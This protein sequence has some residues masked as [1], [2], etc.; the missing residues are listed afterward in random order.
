[1]EAWEQLSARGPG[2][3]W[4]VGGLRHGDL[5]HVCSLATAFGEVHGPGRPIYLVVGSQGQ[6]Q[7]GN[8]FR[9]SFQE[10]VVAHG[11][12]AHPDEWR[13]F[14]KKK[15]LPYFGPDLPLLI[16]PQVSLDRERFSLDFATRNGLTWMQLYKQILHLPADVEPEAPQYRPDSAEDA[17]ALAK[18]VDMPA[19]KSVLLFPYAQSL[20]V[21]ANT[22]FA[23]LAEDLAA[24]GHSVFTSVAPNE[25]PIPGTQPIFVPF[26][27][28]PDL[29]EHA[30]WAVAVRSGICDVLAPVRC[31]KSFIYPNMAEL[32]P[33]SVNAMDYCRD[34]Y[35][36]TFDFN[37]RTQQDFSNLIRS[38]LDMGPLVARAHQ[39][40]SFL[41]LGPGRCDITRL[42]LAE[43]DRGAALPSALFGEERKPALLV[44]QDI[45][46]RA[47]PRFESNT[48]RQLDEMV[49]R[50]PGGTRFFTCRDR[51]F[52]DYF[53]EVAAG[54]LV[55]GLYTA[56]RHW[57]TIAM[58]WETDLPD[59]LPDYAREKVLPSET[60]YADRPIRPSDYHGNANHLA[61]NVGHRPFSC[62]GVQFIEGW[63]GPETWGLWSDS[64]R[65]RLK[66]GFTSHPGA[67]ARLALEFLTALSDS[68]PAFDYRVRVNGSVTAQGR[69][70]SGD[71]R[72]M[73]IA[74]GAM[75]KDEAP[76]ANIVFEFEGLKS[77]VEQGTGPD[78]RLL[79][80]GI[81]ELTVLSG[82]RKAAAQAEAE[83]MIGAR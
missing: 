80:I 8:L 16:H 77:P 10:I 49:G 9:E 3:Y 17:V 7:I 59:L 73:E 66:L 60:V 44:L 45:P 1:M 27:L 35:E 42:T 82:G 6:V 47:H 53:E 11:F 34:A 21:I 43:I 22:H 55:A 72:R 81:T 5:Y 48:S 19:G 74:I 52:A 65:S 13:A 78:T 39:L 70:R 75:L 41:G 40:S 76:V 58:L 50:V 51:G 12:P 63:S 36:V 29:A 62:E 38:R 64:R 24:S 15:G 61:L 69:I 31:R 14:F 18:S 37:G 79:G 28:L 83:D 33:W 32:A 20:P 4:M 67:D 57:H 26:G 54:D 46:Y 25:A 23:R 30:G 2:W 56:S 71:R 68:L